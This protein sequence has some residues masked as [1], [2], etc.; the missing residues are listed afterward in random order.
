MHE[1]FAGIL[2][3][4]LGTDPGCI[5]C[6]HGYSQHIRQ[7]LKNNLIYYNYPVRKEQMMVENYFNVFRLV[8]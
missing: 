1:L 6:I 2:A 3:T 7:K 8:G 4:T 5:L